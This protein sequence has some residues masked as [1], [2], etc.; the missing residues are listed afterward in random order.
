MKTVIAKLDHTYSLS[1]KNFIHSTNPDHR[2]TLFL[3]QCSNNN[4]DD[5]QGQF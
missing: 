4:I 2:D 3:A 1:N 5:R